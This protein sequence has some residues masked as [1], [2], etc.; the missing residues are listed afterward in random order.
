M[1][2]VQTNIMKTPLTFLLSLIF[3]YLFSGSVN[4]QEPKKDL[5]RSKKSFVQKLLDPNTDYCEDRSS[6][7]TYVEQQEASRK[8]LKVVIHCKDGKRHGLYTEWNKYGTKGYY[9]HYKEGKKQ[10]LWRYCDGSPEKCIDDVCY[11]DCSE[12][13]Y[14]DGLKHGKEIDFYRNGNKWVEN[15][16]YEGKKHGIYL[17][18]DEHGQIIDEECFKHGHRYYNV[19]GG[20]KTRDRK[21]GKLVYIPRLSHCNHCT[22]WNPSALGYFS[23]PCK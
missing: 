5:L 8:R 16:Y 14:K 19:D 1:A 23:T 10:G 15:N 3:L 21:S 17:M 22:V 20:Y 12:E 2:I 4:G 13:H 9:G 11:A 6:K 18:R 7:G